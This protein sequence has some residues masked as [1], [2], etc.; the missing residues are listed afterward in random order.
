MTKERRKR[1]TVS[2]GK[3][4]TLP[5][6]IIDHLEKKLGKSGVSNA[7]RNAVVA[8]FSTNKEFKNIKISGLL[9]ER[10]QIRKEMRK[11]Q[12]RLDLTEREL[13]KL[14][15]DLKQGE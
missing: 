4:G 2:F 12:Q 5:R 10:K 9:E 7:I 3:K 11:L 13:N 15:Y 6:A 1:I 8:Y 14:G